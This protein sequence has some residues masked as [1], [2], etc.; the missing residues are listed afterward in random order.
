M[1]TIF[2]LN[3][4]V[5]TWLI[6]ILLL[7]ASNKWYTIY[8]QDLHDPIYVQEML[9]HPIK[10]G[11]ECLSRSAREKIKAFNVFCGSISS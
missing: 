3:A 8:L 6:G 1:S 10:F 2:R 7:R 9:N 11:S 4:N 5:V